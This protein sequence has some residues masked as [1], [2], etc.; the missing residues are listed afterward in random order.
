VLGAPFDLQL[1][2]VALFSTLLLAWLVAALARRFA[3]K[4]FRAAIGNAL[5]PTSP[6][7]RGPLR[8]IFFTTLAL[9][10]ALL[11]FPALDLAGLRPLIGRDWEQVVE[12]LLGAGLRI[13]LIVLVAYALRRALDM[14]IQRFE[15]LA[16]NRPTGHDE[17]RAKRAH[18]V[19]HVIDT[20]LTGLIVG[21]AG[22]MVLNELGVNVAPLLTGA[23]IAGL[24]IGFGAQ[25]LVRDFLSG[26]FLILEDQVRVGDMAA[27]NGT[28]GM[29]EQLNL[30]TIVLRD[31]KG[32]VHV[33][34]NGAIT[35]LANQSKEFS[36]YVIDLN[37]AY[38]EDPDRVAEI[39]REVDR[40]I[41]TDPSFRSHILGPVE[42]LGITE[43]SDWSMLLKVQIET[44]PLK[45]WMVGREFRKRLRKALNRD[46]IAVPYPALR[47]PR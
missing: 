44:A 17:E 30:R 13:V 38:D 15:F 29:V 12:W 6:A 28:G 1:V 16:V 46:G 34:P 26:F 32:T 7:L 25:A 31:A 11:L 35:T 9:A 39:V 2:L 23:G 21:S 33:I 3:A 5:F 47:T 4:A 27:I 41:R 43:F 36:R 24:T 40:E 37:I 19:G 14:L 42:I 10:A 45:Q 20:T 18:T 8:V 22:L